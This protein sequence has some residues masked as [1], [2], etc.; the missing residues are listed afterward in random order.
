VTQVYAAGGLVGAPI[1]PGSPGWLAVEGATIVDVG[2]GRPRRRVRDAGDDVVLV[3]ALVDLQVNGVDDVDFAVADHAGWERALRT[4]RRHGVGAC[5]PTFVSAPL[6]D[7]EERLAFAA[8]AR[9]NASG[10]GCDVVGVH[11]EGPFLGGAPGAHDRSVLVDAD[12]AWVEGA[13][14]RFPGLVRVVTLAPEADPG[15][16]VTRLLSG[17]GVV[18]SLGHTR[19]TYDEALAAIDAGARMATHLF[20]GMAPFRH[21]EP[22]LVGAALDHLVPTVIADLVHLHP[23]VLRAVV[24]RKRE[25]AV[26][27]D[28]V[29]AGGAAGGLVDDGPVARLDDGTLAGSRTFLDEAVR[30]LVAV[31]VT[32]ER[33]IEMASTIPAEVLGLAD[34]GRLAP[35]CRADVLVLDRRTL[36]VRGMLSPEGAP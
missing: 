18:V 8:L 25:V 13:L 3:P 15:L 16:Q 1:A 28:L 12:T 33:A 9:D 17:Q 22:G 5:L 35:G 4:L 32:L 2:A 20:N 23:A 29:A 36:A 30:N 31:G 7:Y 21:R 14:A 11:L 10:A 34:R 19:A 24:A 26:V 6:A 27:S